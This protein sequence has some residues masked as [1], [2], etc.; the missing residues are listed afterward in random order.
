MT[1]K[2]LI[3]LAQLQGALRHELRQRYIKKA[4]EE[5]REDEIAR[6]KKERDRGWFEDILGGMGWGSLYGTGIGGVGGG[7]LGYLSGSTF[8]NMAD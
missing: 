5:S 6:L 1:S 3:K 7:A 4:A 8:G 2:E